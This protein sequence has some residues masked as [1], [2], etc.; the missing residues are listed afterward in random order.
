MAYANL[1]QLPTVIRLKRLVPK[2]VLIN[3]S[4]NKKKTS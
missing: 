1:S 3:V 2:N 4:L